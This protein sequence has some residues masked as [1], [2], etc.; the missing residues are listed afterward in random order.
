MLSPVNLFRPL[1]DW[2]LILVMEPPTLLGALVGA[3]L[4]KVLSETIIAVMLVL[5]LSFTAHNTFKKAIKMYRVESLELNGPKTEPL[6]NQYV[7]LDRND[8]SANNFVDE[9]DN[10]QFEYEEFCL[11]RPNSGTTT[12]S[13]LHPIQLDVPELDFYDPTCQDDHNIATQEF[14]NPLL[15][16]AIIEQERHV[17][18]RSASLIIFMFLVVIVVNVLKGGGGY[19]SPIGIK[20]GSFAFWTVQLLLLGF[21]GIISY[22]ARRRLIRNTQRK[23]DAGYKY[24]KEDVRW[25]ERSTVVYPLV[26]SVAGFCAGM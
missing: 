15:L 8:N 10:E 20:C 25:D 21:I 22:I 12:D 11:N 13:N 26:S 2:D 23:I 9:A 17:N 5:L 19:P 3:N 7:A 24:L 6:L 18:P 16:E 1:I 4:N 14:D